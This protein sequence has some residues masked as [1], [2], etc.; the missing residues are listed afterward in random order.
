MEPPPAGNAAHRQCGPQPDGH[1][2]TNGHVGGHKSNRPARCPLTDQWSQVSGPGTAIFANA[3]PPGHRSI[4][5]GRHVRPRPVGDRRHVGRQLDGDG[6]GR[7]RRG[8]FDSGRSPGGLG[9]RQ[10]DGQPGHDGQSCRHGDVHRRFPARRFPPFGK[11]PT[12]RERSR[13]ETVPRRRRRRPSARPARITCVSWRPMR[14]RATRATRSSPSIPSPSP[15]PSLCS[16]APTATRAC[17]TPI[18]TTRKGNDSVNY[19]T[20]TTLSATGCV[21]EQ[22]SKTP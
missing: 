11:S 2:G 13:S 7:I 22:R 5:G 9:R 19:S 16:R 15:R 4:H 1:A 21:K 18:W 17:R 6:N 10:S 8:T 14:A 20:S 3:S 12:D